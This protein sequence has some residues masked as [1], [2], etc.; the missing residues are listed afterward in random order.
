MLM[1]Y[2]IDY[3]SKYSSSKANLEKILKNKIRKSNIEKKDK[4][5]LYNSIQEIIIKLEKNNFI[6]DFNYASSKIKNF[7]FQG[8]SRI[9]IKSYLFQKGV[10][11]EIISKVLHEFDNEN[12]EW[13]IE[14][15]KILVRK[16]RLKFDKEN[17]SKSLSKMARA[18]FIYEIS[19]KIFE[20]I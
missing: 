11:A 14:C 15:A 2:S 18:G 19:R 7:I 17:K 9:Y 10:E 6:N 3:L 12:S 13:E 20:K 8:K 4:F 1:K 5:I 16:K